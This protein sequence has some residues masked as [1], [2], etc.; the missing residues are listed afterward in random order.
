VR[1][2]IPNVLFLADIPV[3]PCLCAV[4]LIVGKS[5]ARGLGFAPALAA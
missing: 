5:T 4:S 1:R 2:D 3:P